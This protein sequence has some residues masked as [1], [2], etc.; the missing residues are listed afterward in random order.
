LTGHLL[1]RCDQIAFGLFEGG[2]VAGDRD[3]A[4]LAAEFHHGG[5]DQEGQNRAILGA[6]VAREI[7]DCA[8]RFD[9]VQEPTHLVAVVPYAERA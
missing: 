9:E 2:D 7:A 3:H 5:R 8:V 4:V 6:H 1:A